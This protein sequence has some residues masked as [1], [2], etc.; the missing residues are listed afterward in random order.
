MQKI[1]PSSRFDLVSLLFHL[2]L[3]FSLFILDLLH[4]ILS[5]SMAARRTSLDA[6]AVCREVQQRFPPD[7][8]LTGQAS[9]VLSALS[10]RPVDKMNAQRETMEL[11]NA[12]RSRLGAFEFQEVVSR[13]SKQ[14][15]SFPGVAAAVLPQTSR[16]S[17]RV[18]LAGSA[19]ALVTAVKQN[20]DGMRISPAAVKTALGGVEAWIARTLLEAEHF[21]IGR[22]GIDE[23][24]VSTFA[25]EFLLRKEDSAS[26]FPCRVSGSSTRPAAKAEELRALAQEDAE[27]FAR[28]NRVLRRI[29]PKDLVTVLKCGASLPEHLASK[30]VALGSQTAAIAELRT[31]LISPPNTQPNT[32]LG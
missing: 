21:S 29:S 22:A 20:L 6:F 18:P 2:D 25:E 11:V 24:V 14:E 3:S 13:C 19:Q 28:T 30:F 31:R 5:P 15:E 27:T 16:R 23:S 10:A 4:F 1:S 17:S 32:P 8:S 9:R 12:L 7:D 26:L